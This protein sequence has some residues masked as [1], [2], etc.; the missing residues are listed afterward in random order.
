MYVILVLGFALTI[1]EDSPVRGIMFTFILPI[2]P[3]TATLIRIC[4]KF[5]EKPKWQWGEGKKKDLK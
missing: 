1:D 2:V 3:L 4:Y 5:G